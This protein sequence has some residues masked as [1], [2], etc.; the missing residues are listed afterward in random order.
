MKKKCPACLVHF[1]ASFLICISLCCAAAGCARSKASVPVIK[2]GEGA[3]LPAIKTLDWLPE[4]NRFISVSEDGVT[5][6][7]DLF[8]G[9][10]SVSNSEIAHNTDSAAQNRERAGKLILAEDRSIVLADASTEKE[11]ARYYGFDNNEWLCMVPAGFYN[12][13]FRGASFLNVE[14]GNPKDREHRRDHRR[15]RLD[16]FSGALYRPDL[17]K[18]RLLSDQKTAGGREKTPGKNQIPD[19]LEEL[20][21]ESRAAPLVSIYQDKAAHLNREL[22]ITI[23]EQ[24]GGTGFL[25]LYRISGEEEIPAGLFDVKKAASRE[26][27]ENGNTCYEVI[28]N[29]EPGPIGVSAFNK[30]NTVESERLWAG[31]TA[32]EKVSA[33]DGSAAPVLRALLSGGSEESSALSDFLSQQEKGEL[34]SAVKLASLTGGEFGFNNFISAFEEL[35]AGANKNDVFLVYIEGRPQTDLLGNLQIIPGRTNGQCLHGDDLL[36]TVLG[37]SQDSLL[38]L[39]LSGENT[40]DD[41]RDQTD[42]A[43]RR[44]RQRLGPKAMLAGNSLAGPVMSALASG[45][46]KHSG[47]AS[48]GRFASANSFLS[49]A[50]EALAEQGKP[51]LAFHP[52]KDFALADPFINAGELKFQT[53]TSGM[54]K[55]DQVDVN[56]IPL[57][58]GSTMIRTLPPGDYIIDMIYRNG[59]RETRMVNLRRKDSKWVIFNYTPALLNGSG[60]GSLALKG[61]N[62]AELNPA[63]YEKINKEA[64]EGMGM[65][66]YYVAYLAG[67]KFYKDGKYN[68][69]I[70]EYNR[71]IALNAAYAEAYTSRGNSQRR[72]GDYDRAIEDYNKALG[73]NNSHADVYNYRGFAY[74][75][76]G[77]LNRAIT[78]YTQAIKVQ[79]DYTDAYFNRAYAYGKQGSWDAAIADYSQVIKL[80]PSNSVAYRERGNAWKNKGDDSRAEADYAAAERVKK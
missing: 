29:P 12:A 25:A 36:Q 53:M 5:R 2:P 21:L 28:L 1:A 65:A 9:L 27:K 4:E 38:L 47:S 41:S 56:P 17:F 60:L 69:A 45:I 32:A 15:Y 62:I 19:T 48:G 68:E 26:Y 37:L 11:I 16:Q 54:L 63:N 59:Y 35:R 39:D 6:I 72:K 74:T 80:E 52:I 78:D 42:T 75:Q 20:L 18:A 77:E 33:D 34:F 30:N 24:K 22:K 51:F 31:I 58:F 10:V 13:S 7:W 66:P 3:S 79:A 61:I 23:R 14:T 43:L 73:L 44:F 57:L 50:A 49:S 76:K 46:G 40:G 55:I 67:E 70:A 64:M 8:L 71:A